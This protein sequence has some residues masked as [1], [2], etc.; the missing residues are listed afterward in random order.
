MGD[1]GACSSALLAATAIKSASRK[2]FRSSPGWCRSHPGLPLVDTA[3]VIISRLR[4]GLN[5]LTTPAKTTS[6]IACGHGRHRREAV[7][8]CYLN[9][10]RAG[11][12]GP[13]HAPK[14]A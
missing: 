7:L 2:A 1:T 10:R 12:P 9:L 6:R 4:R 13:V 3:L 14:P 8:V 11:H 5:P